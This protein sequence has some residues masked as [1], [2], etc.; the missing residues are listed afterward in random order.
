M[1]LKDTKDADWK[2]MPGET[3]LFRADVD[4]FFSS[5]HLALISRR[6][7][8]PKKKTL[9]V[10]AA[11]AFINT[12]KSGES[13][14]IRLRFTA[15]TFLHQLCTKSMHDC[16]CCESWDQSTKRFSLSILLQNLSFTQTTYLF[17]IA[18][19]TKHWQKK[20]GT[21]NTWPTEIRT[22]LSETNTFSAHTHARSLSLNT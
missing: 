4:G 18:C 13:R 9:G 22:K 6:T 3:F 21:E 10:R 5:D 15:F 1:M 17:F 19:Q 20:K 12:S 8:V 11:S 14:V 7:K 16:W 2:V